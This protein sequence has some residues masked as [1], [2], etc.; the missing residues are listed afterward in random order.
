MREFS[1]DNSVTPYK[2]VKSMTC[3]EFY[4]YA[5]RKINEEIRLCNIRLSECNKQLDS[6]IDE[7]KKFNAKLSSSTT[8]DNMKMI[9]YV[10]GTIAPDR[11]VDE[12][13]KNTAYCLKYK[14][15]KAES[16]SSLNRFTNMGNDIDN[17]A[18]SIQR[19]I[20]YW[21]K[22][23]SYIHKPTENEMNT[24]VYFSF[25][26]N[27]FDVIK[28]IAA[29]MAFLFMLSCSC[30]IPADC[31]E[32]KCLTFLGD[33]FAFFVGGCLFKA[34]P[35]ATFAPIIITFIFYSV[36][37]AVC[38]AIYCHNRNSRIDHHFF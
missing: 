20:D 34:M 14:K 12:D 38:T 15:E 31:F 32:S 28:S 10:M 33:F 13:I 22:E 36:I 25:W 26:R 19:D 29:G 11:N 1:K 4:D 35:S 18:A 30:V 2:K 8:S 23:L 27:F 16:K 5:Y 17:K 6:L 3:Q 7:E 37:G 24:A 21:T 9:K